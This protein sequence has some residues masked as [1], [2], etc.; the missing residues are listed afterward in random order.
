M[1]GP[2]TP[3]RMPPSPTRGDGK[4]SAVRQCWSTKGRP[5]FVYHGSSMEVPPAARVR[6]FD[7]NW[8]ARRRC[9]AHPSDG[10]GYPGRLIF[11]RASGKIDRFAQDSILVVPNRRSS[12]V[13]GT[14]TKRQPTLRQR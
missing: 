5:A 3:C 8:R 12:N 7:S 6:P 1:S 2:R 10:C 11:N 14:S 4:A 13:N 9:I